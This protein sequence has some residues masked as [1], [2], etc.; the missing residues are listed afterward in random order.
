MFFR[1]SVADFEQG[2]TSAVWTLLVG[3]EVAHF[4]LLQLCCFQAKNKG[5]H[6][7]TSEL[8]HVF[9]TRL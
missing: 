2:R 1:V 4:A 5:I 8:S 9:R 3:T 7:R 6:F